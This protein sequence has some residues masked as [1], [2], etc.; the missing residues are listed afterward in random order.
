MS[1]IQQIEDYVHRLRNNI[2]EQV[3]ES[4]QWVLFK[5]TDGKDGGKQ[6]KPIYYSKE[7]KE[8]RSKGHNQPENWHSFEEAAHILTRSG[9]E[10]THLGVHLTAEN[11]W[12]FADPDGA[13][14]DAD[15]KPHAWAHAALMRLNSYTERSVSGG[16]YKVLIKARLYDLRSGERTNYSKRAY[17]GKYGFDGKPCNLELFAYDTNPILLTG[18]RI[19]AYPADMCERQA[20]LDALTAENIR[21]PGRPA[22]ADVEAREFGMSHLADEKILARAFNDTY[23][24]ELFKSMYTQAQPDGE[25]SESEFAL[26]KTL[27]Y[28][29]SRDL[30]TAKRIFRTFAPRDKWS[31]ARDT[32]DYVDFSFEKA[33]RETQVW[34]TPN[35]KLGNLLGNVPDSVLE[36]LAY[37]VESIPEPVDTIYQGAVIWPLLGRPDLHTQ[38]VGSE[39]ELAQRAAK[40]LRSTIRYVRNLGWI[41]LDDATHMWK[42]E[43]ASAVK[44][45]VAKLA[46][47]VHTDYLRVKAL[48]RDAYM[49]GRELVAKALLE[50][51]KALNAAYVQMENSRSLDNVLALAKNTL[52]MEPEDLF[53]HRSGLVLLA[54]GIW[55][56]GVFRPYRAEDYVLKLSS[57]VKAWN[58]DPD[59]DTSELLRMYRYQFDNDEATVKSLQQIAGALLSGSSELRLA[60]WFK[61]ETSTGKGTFADSLT[62]TLGSR[63]A[64]LTTHDLKGNLD[65]ERTNIK[66][67][68]KSLAIIQEAG[69]IRLQEGL[70]KAIT[71]GETLSAR[72]LTFESFM[73]EPTHNLVLTAN[74]AP[75]FDATDA[76]MRKRTIV[77]PFN[78][79]LQAMDGSLQFFGG[80]RIGSMKKEADNPYGH[81]FI[82]FALEGLMEVLNNQGDIYLSPLIKRETHAM[83][84]EAD[85]SADFFSSDVF[86]SRAYEPLISMTGVTPTGMLDIYK[87]WATRNNVKIF[88]QLGRV[89]LKS[90]CEA[91]GLYQPQRVSNKHARLWQIENLE[92]FEASVNPDLTL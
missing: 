62:Y 82:K 90:A 92:K 64:V 45:K 72:K 80:K 19:E 43:S 12:V 1:N 11:D 78:K 67:F 42:E 22:E 24:G 15:G 51:S 5:V 4:K 33:W 88:E 26:M 31:D 47:E 69:N 9:G 14:E 59:A 74:H 85:T 56:R 89:Q 71:G 55:E 61:G 54:N 52:G 21:K 83:F 18:D 70:F 60:V 13:I 34:Y 81:A 2:P 25:A 48:A 36:D 53:Q 46:N 38:I 37:D 30:V 63:A 58:Y 57:P 7:H 77:V 32:G 65:P 87:E 84:K 29:A 23:N 35:K 3:L 40:S 68:G 66:L 41:V 73:F 49:S 91:V 20:E 39:S 6:K 28:W 27:L 44:H 8:F 17:K 79:P 10:C 86:L 75:K 16:G 50:T 76:A